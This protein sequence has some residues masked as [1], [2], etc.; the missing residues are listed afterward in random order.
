VFDAK[1]EYNFWRP[2]TAVRNGGDD[3]NDATEPD[4]GWLSLIDTPMHPEYPCAHCICAGA[5]GEVLEARFGKGEVPPI[6]MTSAG[7]PGVTRRWTRIAD[8]VREVDDARMW[9]GVHYRNSTE[10][11]EA[12]GRRIG[13]L[14][15]ETL[16]T[17]D[18]SRR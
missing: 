7:A 6:E 4:P 17:R 13:K 1:Y 10:V 5:V 18:T 8:Y 15:V 16:L 2:I 11:G 9:G 12:M 14:A 3:G